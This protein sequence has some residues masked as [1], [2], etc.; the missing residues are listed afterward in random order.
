MTQDFPI[1][2][3]G[4]NSGGGKFLLRQIAEAGRTG[5]A[6]S[7]KGFDVPSGITAL[8]LDPAAPGDWHAPKDA[9]IFSLLPIWVLIPLLPRLAG[10][11]AVIAASSTSRFSKTNSSD[12]Q[13]RALAE[14]LAAAES[15]LQL[16]AEHQGSVW[17]ILRPTLVYDC[18]EDRNVTRMATFIRRWRFLPLA[19]PADGL[20]QPIHAEDVA[21]AL[22]KALKN[23]MAA[24]KAFNIS[25]G[26]ILT[27]RAMSERI[28]A[29]LGQRPRF[30]FLNPGWLC[31]ALNVAARLGVLKGDGLNA[32]MFRR[33]NEHLVFE[34]ESGL[35]AL[36]YRPRPFAPVF[37]A[38]E[39]FGKSALR[40]PPDIPSGT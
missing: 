8:E 33:M 35:A 27:Y 22:F 23:P 40:T 34:T 3:L 13:E 24:N 25:G 17:T 29:A 30:L 12:A 11:Q 5:I 1:I 16:W 14:R 15:A 4:G 26:E 20:R 7:R 18:A 28:F 38:C 39:S 21:T 36:G 31:P 6:T 19:W 37:Q 9:V 2:V 32:A 10:A